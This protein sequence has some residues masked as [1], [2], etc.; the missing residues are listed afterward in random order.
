MKR[1]YLVLVV[2]LFSL[3]VWLPFA[4]KIKLP[5]WEMDFS[6]GTKIL[7][8]NYDGPYYMTVEKT[9]YNKEQI[10]AD[11]SSTV[12]TEYYPAHLPLYPAII[13]VFNNLF[14]GPTAMLLSTLIGSVL[15]FLM[16][17]KYLTEF[18]F[19]KYA[20]FF[21]CSLLI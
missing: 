4:L 20:F 6:E 16:L 19:C 15:C 13:W 11:F 1:A 3:V 18:N 12:P 14:K 7:W 8:Q 5:G 10:K 2:V 21:C 9:W 17:F